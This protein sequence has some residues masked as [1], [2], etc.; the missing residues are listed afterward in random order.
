MVAMNALL[1][2][3]AHGNM[4]LRAK[5]N[6]HYRLLS[7]LASTTYPAFAAH[8][9]LH[10]LPYHQGYGAAFGISAGLLLL[11]SWR[12][13]TAYDRLLPPR[14]DA[15]E[16]QQEQEQTS[17]DR[18]APR[19]IT[20]QQLWPMMT[21]PY[22]QALKHPEVLVTVLH[23]TLMSLPPHI[24][25]ALNTSL[26]LELGA[27]EAYQAT[28]TSISSLFA[29]V[30]IFYSQAIVQRLTARTTYVT[31][32]LA[33]GLCLLVLGQSKQLPMATAAFLISTVVNKAMPVAMS[34]WI[35]DAAPGAL[36]TT[37]ISCEKIANSAARALWSEGLARLA[38][39]KSINQ[40]FAGSGVIMLTLVA[41]EAALDPNIRRI[42]GLSSH[43]RSRSATSASNGHSQV[44]ENGATPT[45]NGHSTR[46]KRQ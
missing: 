9:L 2:S 22:R 15:G 36:L 38:E 19:S 23:I 1:Q 45:A 18:L 8:V 34:M 35:A 10:L 37:T 43:A 16:Q 5:L 20:W 25:G 7:A 39:R 4:E 32:S 24:L 30:A 31:L 3:C 28:L 41:A 40:L 14:T 6:S 42:A 26:L 13:D 29:V 21:A 12:L 27:S 11:C 44:V 33:N 17:G 46:K